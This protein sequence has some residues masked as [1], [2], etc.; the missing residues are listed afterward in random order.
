M[1]VIGFLSST[2]Y[3]DCRGAP[4]ERSRLALPPLLL[5]RADEVIE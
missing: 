1:L 3:T 2:F 4:A 5:A